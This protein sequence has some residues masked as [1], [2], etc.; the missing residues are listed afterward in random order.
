MEDVL[1]VDQLYWLN[2][3]NHQGIQLY[4]THSIPMLLALR[5]YHWLNEHWQ[6]LY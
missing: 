3:P 6:Y 4:G 1:Y 5:L 2:I